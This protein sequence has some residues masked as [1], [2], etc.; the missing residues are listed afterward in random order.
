MLERIKS[1]EKCDSK[2]DKFEYHASPFYSIASFKRILTLVI[3]QKLAEGT[4]LNLRRI[5]PLKLI[6]Q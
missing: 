2:S 4:E 3:W 6:V 5:F 1:D